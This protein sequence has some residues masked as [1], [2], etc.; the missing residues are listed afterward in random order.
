MS[1][2]N[3]P[4]VSRRNFLT[5]AIVAVGA[6]IGIVA[7]VPATGV[8]I[9][10]AIKSMEKA[11]AKWFA[12]GSTKSFKIGEPQAKKVKVVRQLGW[13]KHVST[14]TMFILTDDGQ[15]F[16]AM[17][18]V[19]THLGCHVRWLPD[20]NE[21][22]CPCHNGIFDKHGKNISGPPPRP[23]DRYKVKVDNGQLFVYVEG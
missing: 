8:I 7:G 17:S 14:E 22:W 23:L 18:D 19:C 20:K 2:S 9:S 6:F 10:P 4:Q 12:L 21:F 3:D 11:T 16:I 13:R 1:R 15:N 5:G